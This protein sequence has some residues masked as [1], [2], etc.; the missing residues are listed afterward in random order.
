MII[1]QRKC[2]I[3][4]QYIIVNMSFTC[5]IQ[6][7]IMPWNYH[8]FLHYIW[9]LGPN[10]TLPINA[11]MYIYIRITPPHFI[12]MG[13]QRRLRNYFDYKFIDG[14][15]SHLFQE[16]LMNRWRPIFKLPNIRGR[17]QRLAKKLDEW[18]YHFDPRSI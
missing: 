7:R 1:Q 2:V 9:F 15:I 11:Y 13:S 3:E 8:E 12:M 17:N 16:N 5:T 4:N 14:K 10:H 6:I 18:L